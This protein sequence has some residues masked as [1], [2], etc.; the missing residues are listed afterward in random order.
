MSDRIDQAARVLD[1]AAKALTLG[2][3]IAATLGVGDPK[4]R[5][6]WHRIRA[7]RREKRAKK[8][9]SARKA[10]NLLADAAADRAIADVLDP[11]SASCAK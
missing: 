1:T 11:P 10:M 8:A 7:I 9:R 5:A 4:N 6:L 3:R 2:E